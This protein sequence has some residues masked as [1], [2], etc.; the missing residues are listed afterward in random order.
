MYFF[1]RIII[2]DDPFVKK[3]IFFNFVFNFR[4]SENILKFEKKDFFESILNF[5]Y[6]QSPDFVMNIIN[7]TSQLHFNFF[8]TRDEKKEHVMKYSFNG[9]HI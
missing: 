3:C 8:V 5:Q 2:K 6:L 1:V 9:I 4:K 7:I